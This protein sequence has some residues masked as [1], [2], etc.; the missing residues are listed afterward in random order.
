MS[1][2]HMV[3]VWE[4]SAQKGSAL[5]LML[6][7]A[8]SMNDD[9]GQAWLSIDSQ[10][11]KAR[12]DRS[13]V[14]ELHKKLEAAD[15]LEIERGA[16]PHGTNLYR[17]GRAFDVASLAV[18]LKLMLEAARGSEIPTP[19]A[20]DDGEAERAPT[21]GGG[22]IL[23]RVG[24]STP[25]SDPIPKDPVVVEPSSPGEPLQQQVQEGSGRIRRPPIRPLEQAG[26]KATVAQDLEAR[27]PERVALWLDV[28]AWSERVRDERLGPG[29][30]VRA[31]RGDWRPVHGY[32]P[33]DQRCPECWLALETYNA[34]C[35]THGQA[36]RR[37]YVE[38]ELS[39]LIE[40]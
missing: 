16:G 39:H 40:H 7:L 34:E 33:A 1:I 17:L 13:T 20:S 19:T 2:R 21:S 25:E 30:L 28:A 26:V 3:A 31:I 4:R 12:I 36:S 22:R 14:I 27:Y 32:L 23:R 35:E 11:E 8:D 38:G 18:E 6:A 24:S 15:E 10:A 29:F 5:L 37:R 9:S